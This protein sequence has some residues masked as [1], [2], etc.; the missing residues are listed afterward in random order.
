[1]AAPGGRA[2]VSALA[3]VATSWLLVVCSLVAWSLAP[4]ALGWRPTLVVTGSMWPRITPGD[5]VLVEPGRVP[6]RGQVVLLRDPDAATGRV[7]HR[8]VRVQ[9]DG[10]FISQGDANP[11]PDSRVRTT[12]DV[13]GV[14]R[15][16]VPGAGRV[17][18]L[19]SGHGSPAD[20]TWGM[21]T[22]A[23]AVIVVV[24]RR[25]CAVR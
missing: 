12:D 17:A 4:V 18:L 22:L 6:H 3:T 21:L 9:P 24:S 13:I 16:M 5:V 23:A 25:V 8:V 20:R 1:M 7:L 19:G 11:T 15:L 2:T 14:A 10:T